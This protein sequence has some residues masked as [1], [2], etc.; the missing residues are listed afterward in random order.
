VVALLDDGVLL[1]LDAVDPL[2]IG[3]YLGVVEVG[4]DRLT[5]RQIDELGGGQLLGNL[6][7][8][9]GQYDRLGDLD[10]DDQREQ[11]PG[12]DP[13][14]L[15]PG[16]QGHHHQPID[17]DDEHCP[18][19]EEQPEMLDGL[20]QDNADGVRQGRAAHQ[21]GQDDRDA[22]AVIEGQLARSVAQYGATPTRE[23]KEPRPW[24]P[25]APYGYYSAHVSAHLEYTGSNPA[26]VP[27]SKSYDCPS[28]PRLACDQN[29]PTAVTSSQLSSAPSTSNGTFFISDIVSLPS[30]GFGFDLRARACLSWK[31]A[32]T[33]PPAMAN[34]G[35]NRSSR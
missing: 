20:V 7:L 27:L 25:T 29:W 33:S 24:A 13:G 26:C 5:A 10:A 2:L 28:A 17:V 23:P 30:A 4:D 16:V 15:A 34:R 21:P 6:R 8:E 1:L 32:T 12:D 3:D 14:D 19:Q 11:D 22:E 9:E 31:H 35:I 18:D